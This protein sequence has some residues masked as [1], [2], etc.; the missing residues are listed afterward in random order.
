MLAVDPLGW[1]ENT[2]QD[3]MDSNLLLYFFFIRARIFF[4]L[5]AQLTLNS[6]YLVL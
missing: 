3:L 2:C 5:F 4:S 1:P 6:I